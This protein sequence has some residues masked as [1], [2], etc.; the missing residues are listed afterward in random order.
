MRPVVELDQAV[1]SIDPLEPGLHPGLQRWHRV[2]VVQS[3]EGGKVQLAYPGINRSCLVLR[4]AR[5]TVRRDCREA[6]VQ[7]RQKGLD[8]QRYVEVRVGRGAMHGPPGAGDEGRFEIGPSASMGDGDVA[9]CEALLQCRQYCRFVMR[10]RE[11]RLPSRILATHV[12]DPSAGALS[13]CC[14][15]T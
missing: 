8:I 13:T 4:H 5:I 15:S 10:S 1:D 3:R 14:L 12:F 2:G 11:D 7:L 6:L 9:G